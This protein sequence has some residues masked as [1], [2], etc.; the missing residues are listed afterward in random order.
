MIPTDSAKRSQEVVY[1]QLQSCHL[2]HV[3]VVACNQVERENRT[4]PAPAVYSCCFYVVGICT[5]ETIFEYALSTL[6]VSTAVVA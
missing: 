1:F 3:R 2:G 5:L 6:L 4:R